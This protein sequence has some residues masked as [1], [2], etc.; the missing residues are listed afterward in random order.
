MGLTVLQL[1]DR[2]R[3]EAD[4]YRFM[5]EWHWKGGDPVCPHCDNVGASFIQPTNGTSRKTRT[6][7]ISER[8]V[9]RCFSCRKQFS[10]ITGTV[11]HGTKVPLRTWV[12]VVFEMCASKNGVSAREIER[13]YGVCP[14]TAWHMLH[15]I[16]EAMKNDPLVQT[17]RGTIIADETYIGGDPANQHRSV[18]EARRQ[19]VRIV[20]GMKKSGRGTDKP[21]V[22]S[23]IN[24]ATG[25]VRS[26]VVPDVTAA[27]LQKAISEHVDMAGSHLHT[28]GWRA[29]QSIAP[30]FLSHEYVDHDDGEY[31]RGNVTVNH[32]EGYFGQ[33]K[34][35]IDGTHHHISREHLPRYLAEFDYRYSTRKLTD[36]HRM[37]RL[38][39]QVGGRRLTYKRITSA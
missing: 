31:V 32:V 23:L 39:G 17:M 27:T 33:L 37:Q 15:R 16:R 24:K 28:D 25:E 13:K 14:R 36:T 29:Y 4:A 2:L 35:S 8:R 30:Y 12:L 3:S 19:P 11:F 1:A 9:W 7:A 22:L 5:E 18:R 21:A 20:P 26:R 10:V 38:M 6:G 34:R